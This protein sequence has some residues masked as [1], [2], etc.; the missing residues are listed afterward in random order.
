[1]SENKQ[2]K[3]KK[4]VSKKWKIL[5][6]SLAIVLLS[7]LI[8]WGLAVFFHIGDVEYTEDAQVEEYV[9]P[10]STKVTG[11]L[12]EIRFDEHQTVHKGDTLAVID[13]REFK[14]QLLQAEAALKQAEAGK[15][16]IGSDV[17]LSQSNTQISEAN[18]DELKA[19]LENQRQNLERYANLLKADVIPQFEYDQVK[20]EYEAIKARYESSLRQK[21]S[22]QL[23][24]KTIANKMKVSDGDIMRAQAIVDMAKLNLSYCYIIAPYDGIMGRRKITQDQLVQAGQTLSTI[25][26]SGDKWVTANYTEDQIED[27]RIGDKMNIKVDGI[28]NQTFAGEVIAIS[29][30]T[31]SK[32]SATPV[33]N[34]TGNFVKVQQRIPVR[35]K[36]LN[37]KK[38]IEKI[39]AGMNVQVSKK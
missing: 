16:V 33:D 10:I 23:N 18:I 20:T 24:T 15:T 2:P 11:Y 28:K 31:G 1:M 29:G 35:I 3:E 38:D 6:N 22:S 27:I 26:Q 25:V 14:I 30:A 4:A 12:K 7:L 19:R 13:D 9:S 32:Y 39:R 5:G 17:N 21:Q 36:F 34:S 37:T 8:F